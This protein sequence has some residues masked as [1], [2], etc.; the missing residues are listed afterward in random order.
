MGY[1]PGIS[2]RA[3]CEVLVYVLL[4]RMYLWGKQYGLQG[5][6][7]GILY[8]RAAK[9]PQPMSCLLAL[10][11]V[12]PGQPQ[13]VPMLCN[14]RALVNNIRWPERPGPENIHVLLGFLF[15]LGL[16]VPMWALLGN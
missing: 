14:A 12:R 11:V 15:T 7:F 1:A 5:L 2:T 9:Y 4:S 3:P 10:R 6:A 13:K 16:I 8:L